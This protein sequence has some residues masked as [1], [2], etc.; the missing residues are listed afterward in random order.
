MQLRPVDTS[1]LGLYSSPAPA[2]AFTRLSPGHVGGLTFDGE[3]LW[4][5]TSQF[6]R[7]YE[8]MRSS[9]R[10]QTLEGITDW[11]TSKGR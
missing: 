9:N 1:V 4:L 5:C 8:L 7:S 10:G 6:D 11:P 3:E 2:H